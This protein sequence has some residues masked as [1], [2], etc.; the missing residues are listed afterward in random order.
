VHVGA[1][2]K[3]GKALIQRARDVC[4]AAETADGAVAEQVMRLFEAYEHG[5]GPKRR[6]GEFEAGVAAVCV[7][8]GAA[9]ATSEVENPLDEVRR[10]VFGSTPI[11]RAEA[12]NFK[13]FMNDTI[14]ET[15]SDPCNP[16]R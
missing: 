6:A 8:K 3:E 14:T 1:V 9:M 11:P 2:K 13:E 7:K 10:I 16:M 4:R 15:N 12:I 5:L